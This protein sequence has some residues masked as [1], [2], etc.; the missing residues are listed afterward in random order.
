MRLTFHAHT[1]DADANDE[2]AQCSFIG[3]DGKLFGLM[4]E[5][6]T[7]VRMTWHD[8]VA[9]ADEDV[10]GLGKVAVTSGRLVLEFDREAAGTWSDIPYEGVEITFDDTDERSVDLTDVLSQ[11]RKA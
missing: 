8:G 4:T 5:D 2:V 9:G 3:T 11:M 10:I 1:T 6:G 7:L